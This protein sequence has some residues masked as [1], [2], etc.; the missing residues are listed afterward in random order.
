MLYLDSA[1]REFRLFAC[2]LF[3]LGVASAQVYPGGYP[4]RYPGGYPGGYPGTGPGGG[5]PLPSRKSKDNKKADSGQPLP[6]FRGKLKVMDDKTISLELGDNRVLDFKRNSKTKFFKGG[7]E[8][9]EPK[10]NIG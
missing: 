9:K 6:N 2:A 3:A 5:I 4:G 8:I 7:D 1:A 10:F